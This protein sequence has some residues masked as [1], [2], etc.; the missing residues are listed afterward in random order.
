MCFKEVYSPRHTL[1]ELI[2]EL[3]SSLQSKINDDPRKFLAEETLYGI[4]PRRVLLKIDESEYQNLSKV[5]KTKG[6]CLKFLSRIEYEEVHLVGFLDNKY[7]I[8]NTDINLWSDYA[9]IIYIPHEPGLS[10][11]KIRL[12]E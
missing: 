7:M 12:L 2:A 9:E 6:K 11:R 4:Q 1:E 10:I 8:A 3:E 5:I